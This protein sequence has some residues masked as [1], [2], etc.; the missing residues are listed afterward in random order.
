MPED[1]KKHFDHR[2][3]EYLLKTEALFVAQKQ[4]FFSAFA[5]HFHSI[6]A[7]TLKLQNDYVIQAISRLEYTMLY[8]NFI[9]RRYLV[10]CKIQL[11]I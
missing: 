7:E 10:F 5:Q 11:T 9:N 1:F 4:N 6:C 2:C 8:S 3:N